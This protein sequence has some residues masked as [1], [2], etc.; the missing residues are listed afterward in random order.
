MCR[1]IYIHVIGQVI[2]TFTMEVMV[3]KRLYIMRK[4]GS[5]ANIH[6]HVCSLNKNIF[7][8]CNLF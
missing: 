2:A 1:S 3:A 5:F 6:V 4:V 8:T 7:S